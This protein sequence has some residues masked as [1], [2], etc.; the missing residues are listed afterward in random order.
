MLVGPDLANQPLT[1]L[2]LL[3]AEQ[4]VEVHGLLQGWLND[5]A[6]ELGPELIIGYPFFRRGVCSLIGSNDASS[7][8]LRIQCGRSVEV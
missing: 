1:V 8:D 5:E 3:C 6:I 7:I 2:L 4:V